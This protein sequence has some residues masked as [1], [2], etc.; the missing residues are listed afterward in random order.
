MQE[1]ILLY[2]KPPEIKVEGLVL[3][4]YLLFLCNFSTMDR[5]EKSRIK[6][7]LYGHRTKKTIKGRTYESVKKGIIEELNGTRIG[8]GDIAIPQNNA[9][10]LQNFFDRFHVK[11]KMVAIWLTNEDTIKL[12]KS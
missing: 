1:G 10:K 9:Y 11:Y 3:S 2:A 8:S 5:K 7:L 4:P 6:R 12:M